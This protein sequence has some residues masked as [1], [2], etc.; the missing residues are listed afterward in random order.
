MR[1]LICRD[2]IYPYVFAMRTPRWFRILFCLAT[3]DAIG[4]ALVTRY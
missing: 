2:V 3:L 1:Y 4:T